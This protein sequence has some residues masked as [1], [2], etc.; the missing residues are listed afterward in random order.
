MSD[1]DER[2]CV[3]ERAGT[4]E[5]RNSS[6]SSVCLVPPVEIIQHSTA[7]PTVGAECGIQIDDLNLSGIFPNKYGHHSRPSKQSRKRRMNASGDAAHHD[8]NRGAFLK[9]TVGVCA[10]GSPLPQDCTHQLPP[11][12]IKSC[13]IQ[14]DGQV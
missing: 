2:S 13:L 8:Q 1:A 11:L 14:S 7:A 5:T 9:R 12:S 4:R 3:L 10:S 6:S